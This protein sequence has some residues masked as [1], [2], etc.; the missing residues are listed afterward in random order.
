MSLQAYDNPHEALSR[1]KRHLLTQRTFKEV[2][3]EFMDLYRY[4]VHTSARLGLFLLSSS[5]PC[6]N[7]TS[8]TNFAAAEASQSISLLAVAYGMRCCCAVISSPCMRLSPWRRSRTP[9]WTSTCGMRLTSV[10][11]SPT[12]SSQLTQSRHRCLS[13]S[14]MLPSSCSFSMKR[15]SLLPAMIQTP[16][17]AIRHVLGRPFLCCP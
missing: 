7:S 16:Y 3:I 9:T 17:M 4:K 10:T 5:I 15:G 12:G 6:C 14:G 8:S 2:S 11:C 1:I 13:T